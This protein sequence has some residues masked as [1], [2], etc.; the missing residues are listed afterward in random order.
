[1]IEPSA[2]ELAIYDDISKLGERLWR[3][4][5]TIEGLS[6]DPKMFSIM[7][8]KRLWS[9]HRGYTLLWK[10]HLDLE[11]NIVLR[12][13]VE[14]AIAIAANMRLGREFVDLM[15][16]DAI[17][18]VLGQ[19]KLHRENGD[20]DAEREAEAVVRQIRSALPN[21]VKSAAL[22][23]KDLADKNEV[24]QLYFFHKMLSSV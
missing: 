8:Y 21:G 7:L 14:A 12:S 6:T 19:I 17:Y 16:G 18:S 15:K 11:A 1:M 10:S 4:S 22:N 5:T 23:W 9:N 20:K 2:D 24:P 3:I 13:A